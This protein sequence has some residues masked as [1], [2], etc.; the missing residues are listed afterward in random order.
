MRRLAPAFRVFRTS[1]RK[2]FHST[3][4]IRSTMPSSRAETISQFNHYVNMT[5]SSLSSW[6]DTPS[7]TQNCGME[8][9]DGSG[10]TVGHESG[11]QILEILERNPERRDEGYEE[12]DLPF[13]RKVVGYW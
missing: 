10:E 9:P 12:E 11:R 13:M 4:P 1:T 8:K 6:L 3:P 7:S 5:P 2:F